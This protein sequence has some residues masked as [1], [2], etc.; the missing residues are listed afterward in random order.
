MSQGQSLQSERSSLGPQTRYQR[1][2]RDGRIRRRRF[3]PL[4][5]DRTYRPNTSPSDDAISWPRQTNLQRLLRD[6]TAR[7]CDQFSHWPTPTTTG[8]LRPTSSAY[9]MPRHSPSVSPNIA[10]RTLE[11]K[12]KRKKKNTSSQAAKWYPIGQQAFLPNDGRAIL[13]ASPSPTSGQ[14]NV[15]NRRPCPRRAALTIGGSRVHLCPPLC[16]RE[17]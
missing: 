7:P 15:T 13:T 6:A 9:A 4:S 5:D 11:I 3:V 14:R 16:M 1:S 17:R 8:C 12:E 10:C 2:A